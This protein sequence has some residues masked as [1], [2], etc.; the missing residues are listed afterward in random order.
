MVG[1]VPFYSLYSWPAGADPDDHQWNQFAARNQWFRF[2]NNDA[3]YDMQQ[4]LG[5]TT[6]VIDDN[7]DMVSE[8]RRAFDHWWKETRPLMINEFVSMSPT[9]PYHVWYQQQLEREHL[10]LGDSTTV[11]DIPSHRDVSWQAAQTD[12][13]SV[14]D[15]GGCSCGAGMA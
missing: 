4:D 15:T 6:N 1:P 8:M 9:R 10:G 13:H 11:A 5:Q 12:G 3:L 14:A 2:V 7:P